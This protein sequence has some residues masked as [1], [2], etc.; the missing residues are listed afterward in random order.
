[1]GVGPNN[2]DGFIVGET[3]IGDV[4]YLYVGSFMVGLGWYD[5]RSWVLTSLVVIPNSI[6]YRA[7]GAHARSMPRRGSRASVIRGMPSDA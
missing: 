2:G 5:G 7:S 6:L 1:M 3:A 4:G